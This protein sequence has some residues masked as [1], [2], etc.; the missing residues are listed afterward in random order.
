[1]DKLNVLTITFYDLPN[2]RVKAV[3]YAGTNNYL[4]EVEGGDRAHA[5]DLIGVELYS[6]FASDALNR[7]FEV[8]G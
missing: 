7:A 3:A 8:R 2:T 5:T 1:M 4:F 6:R